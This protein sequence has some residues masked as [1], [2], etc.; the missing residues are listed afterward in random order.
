MKIYLLCLSFTSTFSW[1]KPNVKQK[2]EKQKNMTKSNEL[3]ILI[4]FFIII[5]YR[6]S[7]L[8]TYKHK[9]IKKNPTTFM[10]PFV[11]HWLFHFVP[12]LSHS[13]LPLLAPF[14]RVNY[15]IFSFF[16]ILITQTKTHKYIHSQRILFSNIRLK[17][18]IPNRK[19]HWLNKKLYQ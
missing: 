14:S 1:T 3:C 2:T 10:T 16:F 9:Y 12:F 5:I 11:G 15:S 18:S 13:F 4:H 8:Y 17:K 19:T 7:I 6:L